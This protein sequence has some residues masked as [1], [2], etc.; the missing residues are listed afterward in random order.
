[1]KSPILVPPDP[2]IPCILFTDVSKYAWSAALTQGY[3]VS[4]DGK[5]ITH[6]H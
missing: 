6:Q 2:D 5:E 3:I 1:M 4:I